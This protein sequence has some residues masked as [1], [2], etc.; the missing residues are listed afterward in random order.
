MQARKNILAILTGF[1]LA[2]LFISNANAENIY[3][4]FTAVQCDSLI[5]ANE[6]NPNFVV[7]DVRT[8]N[9]WNGY[10]IPGAINRSTGL[11]DF[12][13]EL[14]TLP[15][16]KIFVLHCQSGGRSAG[17]FQKMKDL[18]FAEV[19][20]MIG[21]INAWRSA[22]LPTTTGEQPK[23]MLVDYNTVSGG[24]ADT[25]NITVTNRANGVLTFTTAEFD[26][27]H[28]VNDNFNPSSQIQGAF[29]YTFSVIHAPHYT[30]DDST[31]ILLES[32]GGVLDFTLVFKDGIIQGI[33][34]PKYE[35]LVVYPNP[36]REKLFIKN[37]SEI[38]EITIINLN[39]QVVLRKPGF[40]VYNGINVS[41]LQNGIYILRIQSNGKITARKFV[42]KH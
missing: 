42:V 14:S 2:L 3:K 13:E 41:T 19:Y 31:Q 23:L 24:S 1:I 40:E 28:S 5:K 26:D 18:Q 35:E 22:A 33:K 30:G 20:E 7:L 25:L 34:E 12:T 11:P 27:L 4:R 38:E 32:N 8:P 15:K 17:A 36:A 37:M 16:H 39:G 9:E 29:D 6:T 10:H 21:G